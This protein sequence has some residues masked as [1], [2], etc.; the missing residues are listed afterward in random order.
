MS[1]PGRSSFR[2]CSSGFDRGKAVCARRIGTAQQA[3]TAKVHLQE[4]RSLTTPPS[5]SPASRPTAET[6][7]RIPW[8]LPRR[9]GGNRSATA[10]RAAVMT[11]PAPAPW[12]AV[13]PASCTIDRLTSGGIEPARISAVPT[14]RIGRRPNTSP[15]RPAIGIATTEATREAVSGHE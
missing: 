5:A 11:L 7:P 14:I 12:I 13:A 1:I 15:R 3:E 6:A 8:Y 10:A 4:R 2:L 9:S